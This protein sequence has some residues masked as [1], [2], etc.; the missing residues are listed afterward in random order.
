V[1]VGC[2]GRSIGQLEVEEFLTKFGEL[3]EV[4]F[5]SGDHNNDNK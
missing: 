1:Y 3:K 2:F 5:F 4:N